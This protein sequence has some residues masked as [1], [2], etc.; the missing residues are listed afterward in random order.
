[1][2]RV[3][4]E[5]LSLQTLHYVGPVCVLL[6]FSLAKTAAT[7]FLHRPSKGTTVATRRYVALAL[8]TAVCTTLVGQAVSRLIQSIAQPGTWAPQDE[9]VYFLISILAYG[10]LVLGVAENTQPIWHP[11]LGSFFV[12]GAFE[13]AITTLEALVH[14]AQNDFEFTRL[15]LQSVRTVLLVVLCLLGSWYAL[16]DRLDHSNHLDEAEPLISNGGP[17]PAKSYGAVPEQDDD[18]ATSDID[19]DSDEPNETRELRKKQRKRVEEKGSWI[20]YLKEFKVFLPMLWPS[21]DRIVQACLAAIGAVLVAE[22]FLNVLV[23]RYLGFITDDLNEGNGVFP[24][25]TVALWMLFSYLNSSAGLSVVKSLAE[26]PVQQFAYKSIGAT[27]FAHIMGLSMDFH[28]EKNSGELIRACDQGQNL[29]G[30]L[31]FALFQIAPMFI[32]LLIA[33]VY[34]YLLFDVYMSCIL[35]FVGI[36]YIWVGAK[37][38]GWSVRRRR[39][40]NTAWRN[41]SKVQNE[42][43]NNW[44]TV[45]HFNRGAYECDRYSKS[46]D[47]FNKAEMGYFISYFIGGGVQ[48]L[49]MVIGRLAASFW[50]I[51]KVSRGEVKVGNFITLITYWR[52]IESPLMQVSWSIRRVTQMLTDSERLLQLFQTEPSVKDI[53]DAADIVIKSGEVVFED[54]DFAYDVRKST[55][56]SVTFTAKPG[57]TVALVGETGGGKSTILKL[58]YRYYDVSAGSIRIDGQDIREVTLDSLRD[59]FGMVPQDP[60]LFNISI[61]ENVRYARLDATDEEVKDA[62]RAAA[63]HDKI[64]GFPD[65]YKSTV[66][67]RGV[68]LS[69]GELQRVSIARAILR[70]PKIVLLDEATSMIDAETEAVIQQAFRR[71]TSDRTTFIIAHRLSTIQHADLILVIQDGKVIERGTHDELFQMDG[72]YVAL[73]SRQLSKDVKTV[74]TTLHVDQADPAQL[75]MGSESTRGGADE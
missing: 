55:L 27:S 24:A 29:Q 63:I 57:Q 61:M 71:L 21:R 44:Q 3:T 52:S 58:L 32:D 36:A 20:A 47:E 45:S 7:C 18:E 53:P 40:F 13:V 14:G 54:V 31:E 8:L 22:R 59:S 66:G 48:S 17:T 33:F 62:C 56:K 19:S 67:E 1:M 4:S 37:T 75:N 42:A 73:W 11:Y 70:Q 41:E 34:V 12:G 51:Y 28:N 69:G 15:A 49:I 74:G 26:L 64:E 39:R 68:K 50:A 35:G 2:A 6:Y 16:Q 72:K 65:G 23:P 9:V 60:A 30:L 25:H 46:I 43:I 5:L 38:T 10:S